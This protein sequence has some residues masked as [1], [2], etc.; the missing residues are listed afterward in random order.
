MAGSVR[1]ADRRRPRR[2]VVIARG[3]ADLRAAQRHTRPY[4]RRSAAQRQRAPE[5]A[6]EA[7]EQ[8]RRVRGG[9]G[10]LTPGPRVEGKFSQRPRSDRVELA[11]VLHA[12]ALGSDRQR[13]AHEV[14]RRRCATSPERELGPGGGHRPRPHEV[15]GPRGHRL[16]G[17][18]IRSAA[19]RSP[20]AIA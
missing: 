15:V 11:G 20:H 5:P 4:P 3:T 2:V 14:G 17:A 19:S 18:Q 10:V 12:L 7:G 9:L 6:L 16:D 1:G 8:Y 13:R